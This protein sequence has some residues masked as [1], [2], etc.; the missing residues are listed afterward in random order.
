MEKTAL[1]RKKSPVMKKIL[2]YLLNLEEYQRYAYNNYLQIYH[3]GLHFHPIVSE[4]LLIFWLDS[5]TLQVLL[6]YKLEFPP[7]FIL[8][9]YTD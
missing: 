9:A 5:I 1:W 8:S 4:Y 6:I 2:P 7:L 3:V